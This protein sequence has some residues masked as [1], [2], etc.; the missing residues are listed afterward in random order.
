[1]TSGRHEVAMNAHAGSKFLPRRALIGAGLLLAFAVALAGA[2]RLTGTGTVTLPAA[3]AEQSRQL[4]FADRGDGA[5]VVIDTEASREIEVLAPG[6]D[7]FIRGVMRSLVRER[8]AHGVSQD[9]PFV[10]SRDADH[11]LLLSDPSTGRVI[12]LDAFGSTN[13]AAFARLLNPKDRP[14]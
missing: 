6:H 12:G 11:R 5:V 8:T 2:G 1:M 13:A 14:S 9:L 3:S 7:N 10:L 4:R